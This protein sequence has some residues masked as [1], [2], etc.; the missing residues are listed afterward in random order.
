LNESATITATGSTGASPRAGRIL[1]ATVNRP[2]GDTGVHAHTRSLC[3]GL[4]SAGVSVD[5]VSPSTGTSKWLP[6]FAVR[7]LVL[8]RIN[9]TWGTRWYRHWHRIALEE[10]LRGE[11]KHS[12][13]AAVV[14]QCPVSA[15]A[16]L[17]VRASLGM[18]FPIAMVCHFNHSEATEYREKGECSDN[19]THDAILASETSLLKQVD[20]VFYVSQ[21]SRRVVE[22]ERGINPRTSAVIW[23]GIAADFAAAA[24]DRRSLGLAD[25]DV[26]IVNVGS[27]EARKNQTGLLDLFARIAGEYPKAKLVLVGDGP[28]R[29]E[30]DAKIRTL[31]LTDRVKCLGFRSDVPAIFAA[32]D[33]YIHYA[34]LENCPVILLEAAR[35]GLP[36]ASLPAGGSQ[37]ILDALGGGV[38]LSDEDAEASMKAL[39]PLLW[40]SSARKS[41]GARLRLGFQSRFTQAAMTREYISRLRSLGTQL[42]AEGATA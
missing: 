1:I 25:D 30:I 12:P 38:L 32:S 27:L 40:E 42:S 8:K 33:L 36:I 39:R 7:P 34:K 13:P 28:Q 31:C 22:V 37:E 24:V 3:A 18:D 5:V 29:G 35:A 4:R 6:I 16:A 41:M 2:V 14:A 20:A 11:L 26:V 19:A 23:N 15:A 9:K 10:R 17:N 21:W